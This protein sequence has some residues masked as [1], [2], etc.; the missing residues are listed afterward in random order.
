MLKRLSAVLILTLLCGCFD[1]KD[2]LTLEA[3]GSGKVRIETTSVMDPEMYGGGA[4]EMSGMGGGVMYPPVNETE[5][6]KFFPGKEFDVSVKQEKSGQKTV[7]LVEAAFKDVNAL[8]RSPYGRAHQLVLKV[9][10][11]DLVLKGV[12]G[13]EGAARLTEVKDESGMGADLVPGMADLEKNRNEMRV[14]FRM[15]LPGT[16][17]GGN[18]RQEGRSI[19]WIEDRKN[20]TNT[21]EFARQLSVVCEARCPAEGFKIEPMNPAR[22]ALTSFS[23]LS[24]APGTETVQGIDTNAISGAAKFVPYALQVTRSVD[25]SGEGGSHESGAVLIGAV[26]VP[27]EFQ[28]QKWGRP[29]LI[30]AVDAKGNDLKPEDSD[31]NSSFGMSY[32]YSRFATGMED[33]EEEEGEENASPA[34]EN[35]HPVTIAFRPP[36]WKVFEIA[37]IR[38]S[39]EMQYFSGAQVIKLTNAVPAS[40]IVDQSKMMEAMG[41]GSGEKRLSDPALGKAGIDLS[42]NMAMAQNGFTMLMLGM[43]A[44][45]AALIDAQVFD[46]NGKAWPTFLQD[47]S[48]LASSGEEDA[49]VTIVVAGKPQPPLSLAFL[50][51]G[52]GAAVEIPIQ[53]DNVP[54]NAK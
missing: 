25:L 8:L 48:E 42:L 2:E 53:L 14:E 15:T 11:K 6:R 54:V 33:G 35:R 32:R 12:T 36:D 51:S 34:L 50:V 28:P 20:Y 24:L 3:D 30:E 37:R 1:V 44:K 23:E 21:T 16:V 29:K 4:M 26:V 17:T 22:L 41:M 45:S 49:T 18:G 13:M 40:W 10:G 43:E 31:E 38:G 46:A 19:T 9:D 27:M 47:M 39:V 52:A 7:T 5:A